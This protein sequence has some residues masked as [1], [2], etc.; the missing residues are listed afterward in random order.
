MILV[1]KEG[2][3]QR[4]EDSWNRVWIT[5]FSSMLLSIFQQPWTKLLHLVREGY[6]RSLARG[7]Q[8]WETKL[9]GPF[10]AP[11]NI[12]FY[13]TFAIA[14]SIFKSYFKGTLKR[15]GFVHKNWN[16]LCL[17]HI[18]SQEILIKGVSEVFMMIPSN[19]GL[20]FTIDPYV[21]LLP[22]VWCAIQVKFIFGL[23]SSN[24]GIDWVILSISWFLSHP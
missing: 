17:H 16:F 4:A 19:V 8:K 22:L 18:L 7:A 20:W 21:H 12:A 13:Y 14:F 10:L 5:F 15:V 6:T 1:A 11:L 3:I 2:R 23:V 24:L 9:I